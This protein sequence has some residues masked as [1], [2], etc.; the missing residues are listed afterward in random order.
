WFDVTDDAELCACSHSNEDHFAAAMCAWVDCSCQS[1]D[2]DIDASRDLQMLSLEA[3]FAHDLGHVL[4]DREVLSL[5]RFEDEFDAERRAAQLLRNSVQME[6][7]LMSTSFFANPRS[8]SH[9]PSAERIRRLQAAR[10]GEVRGP[11]LTPS[12]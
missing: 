10:E 11:I 4:Q 8:R 2:C 3:L 6:R 1:F 9:P 7:A 12:K 5:A